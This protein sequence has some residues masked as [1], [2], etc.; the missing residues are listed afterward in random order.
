MLLP[1]TIIIYTITIWAYSTCA[2]IV[3]HNEI[4]LLF[5]NFITLIVICTHI[6]ISTN[7]KPYLIHISILLNSSCNSPVL[8]N[9]WRKQEILHISCTLVFHYGV[10]VLIYLPK[11]CR[12]LI[13]KNSLS[14]IWRVVHCWGRKQ[15]NV[16]GYTAKGENYM[17]LVYIS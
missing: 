13:E 1:Y 9:Y 14:L 7:F 6:I 17:K 2:F 10:D 4:I 8:C 5:Y 15:Y 3:F 16:K 11:D 12:I